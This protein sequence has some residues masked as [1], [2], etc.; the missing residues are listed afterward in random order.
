MVEKIFYVQVLGEIAAL[1]QPLLR[2]GIQN[3]ATGETALKRQENQRGRQMRE[4]SVELSPPSSGSSRQ[5]SSGDI[6]LRSG[7]DGAV[8][9]EVCCPCFLLR[10]ISLA[11]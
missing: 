2:S 10:C 8:Q 11:L 6:T 1:V 9:E 3:T 5:R 7:M 4:T